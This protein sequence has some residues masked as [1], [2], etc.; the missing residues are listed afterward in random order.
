VTVIVALPPCGSAMVGAAQLFFEATPDSDRS[1]AASRGWRIALL[2]R[3]IAR[4]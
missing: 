3:W 2:R 1:L 4:Q